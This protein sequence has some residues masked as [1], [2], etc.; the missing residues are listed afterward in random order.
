MIDIAIPGDRP[1]HPFQSEQVREGFLAIVIHPDPERRRPLQS[2]LAEQGAAVREANSVDVACGWVE[3]LG[4]PDLLIC[5]T[6]SQPRIAERICAGIQATNDQPY[7]Y[8]VVLIEDRRQAIQAMADGADDFLVWTANLDVIESRLRAIFRQATLRAWMDT[9]RKAGAVVSGAR[10]FDG[11]FSDVAARLR[12]ILPVDHFVVARDE[13]DGVRFEVVDMLSNGSAPWN[14]CL[15]TPR[16]EACPDR[17]QATETGYRICTHVRDQD[18]RLAHDMRSCMCIPLS[19]DGRVIGSLSL[20]SRKPE[21]FEKIVMPHLRSLAVQVGHAVANIERYEQVMSET[22]RLATI[23]R[24][25]H[26]R[27][28]NNLQGVIGL[29]AEHRNCAPELAAILNNA[30]SQLHTVAEVHNLLSH[31]TREQVNLH[32]LIRAIAQHAATLCRHHIDVL[33]PR[34]TSNFLVPASEAVP[35]ALVVNELIQNAIKHGYPDGRRGTIRISLENHQTLRLRV[36]NNAVPSDAKTSSTPG[37]GLRLVRAL[38]PKS[39]DFHLF[40]KDG[41]THAEVLLRDWI[42]QTECR[43]DNRPS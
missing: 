26:H 43:L 24:E 41:W 42:N 31:H 21:A 11:L 15:R 3:K 12:Q 9:I 14:F 37:L 6:A 22:E 10:R 36:A 34:D 17:F 19:D 38:L 7:P 27:I 29:L 16:A 23:V 5:D 35:F 39:C 18:P 1:V 33:L 8:T 2:L 30:I 4:P 32:E 13:Q 20:A 40:P 28:K 25:V